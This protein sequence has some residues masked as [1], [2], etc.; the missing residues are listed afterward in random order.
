M[1]VIAIDGPSGS[2]KSSAAK[3]ISRTFDWDYLDTGALYRM[4]TLFAIEANVQEISKIPQLLPRH[5]IHWDGNPLEPK[6]FLYGRDVSSG[7]RSLEVTHRVSE[8]AADSE[9]RAYLLEIQREIINGAIHG[10]VVEGRDIGTTVWPDAELKIFLTADLHARAARRSAELSDEITEGEVGIALSKRD[11]IDSNRSASPLRI[12]DDQVVV[13]ATN[14]TL[15]EVVALIISMI[16]KLRLS[17]G[18]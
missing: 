8:I 9:V 6:I 18:D 12:N 4:L 1:V 17:N 10:I 5:A 15:N 11:D 14:L 3:E 16:Q 7:I 2:G 13:D